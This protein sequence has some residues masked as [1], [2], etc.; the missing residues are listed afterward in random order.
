VE[1]RAAMLLT[2]ELGRLLG[3]EECDKLSSVDQDI[4]RL[5]TPL[6]KLYTARQVFIRHH[7]Y[8]T[9]TPAASIHHCTEFVGDFVL[10]TEHVIGS[11][12]SKVYSDNVHV[13]L[14]ILCVI[15]VRE[16]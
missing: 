5:L 7:I 16:Y 12:I 15:F 11:V 4:L 8:E 9:V 1:T 13:F 2:F 3:F 6:A 10:I 14:F